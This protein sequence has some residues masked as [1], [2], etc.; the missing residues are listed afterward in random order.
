MH[1]WDWP[2]QPWQWI[3]LDY[4]SPFMGKMFFVAI[5]AHS[6]WMEVEVVNS[7]TTQATVECL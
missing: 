7:V 4:A 3:Y 2:E 5:D 6:K 1:P